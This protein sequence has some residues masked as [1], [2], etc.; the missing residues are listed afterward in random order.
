MMSLSQGLQQK[1]KVIQD[2]WTNTIL[3][4][5]LCFVDKDEMQY[6]IH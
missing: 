5:M 6:S 4:R 3:Y 1:P 2:D